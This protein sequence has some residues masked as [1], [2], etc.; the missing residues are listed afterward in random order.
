MQLWEIYNYVKPLNKKNMG[1]PL[2]G[3]GSSRNAKSVKKSNNN[4]IKNIE[5]NIENTKENTK[6]KNYKNTIIA[7]CGMLAMV[8]LIAIYHS[9]QLDNIKK[10]IQ[11]LEKKLETKTSQSSVDYYTQPPCAGC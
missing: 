3:Y 10:E 6:E 1:N 2:Y 7:L 8:S 4:D 9:I 11:E 5:K